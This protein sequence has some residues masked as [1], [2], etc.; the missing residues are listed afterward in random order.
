MPHQKPALFSPFSWY[1]CLLIV[2]IVTVL[3]L[4]GHGFA[5]LIIVTEDE[6]PGHVIFN[7]TLQRLGSNRHYKINN[8]KTAEFVHR[9]F[10][11]NTTS[12]QVSLK[13][14]LEC[15]GIFYPNLFTIYVDSVSNESRGVDYYSIP[16]RIFI[17]G[18]KCGDTEE[19]F[20]G[21]VFSKKIHVKISEAK[22]WISET[23]ASYAIPGA[24]G[25]KQIC[26]RKSQFI[27]SLSSFMPSTVLKMCNVCY[28]DSNN[29]RF[30]IETKAGD[31]VSAEDQCIV[32]PLWKVT[33]LLKFVCDSQLTVGG[34]NVIGG[35]VSVTEHRL[36]IIFHHQDLN[37][38]DIAHRV[39]RE[40]RNQSPYFEQALYIAS[41]MEEKPPGAMVATVKAQDPEK[42][43]VSYS[44]VSLLDSRSQT[45]F[46]V[47][48][49]SGIVT[50]LT[51]LDRELVDMHYFRVTAV[52]DSFPPRSGTTT[53]QI[54]VLDAN[55]HAP[56][57]EAS[58]YEAAVRES[59]SVGSTVINL[60]ATDQDIN[61][62]AEVS[63][64]K[65]F[66]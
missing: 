14:S 9:L 11:V 55:D 56:E 23:L 61:R 45:M 13:R 2:T 34:K 19:E 38:T 27:S 22:K 35:L 64:L 8:H 40:L 37:D 21:D 4:I 63:A 12:G 58:E 44:M 7:T 28:I 6:P 29:P 59:V 66:S 36:K 48:P 10:H 60:R 26:L 15:D 17:S 42:S 32:E 41:V 50:T 65:H 51:S 46:T 39:R 16:L 33:V 24:D 52:D 20:D 49:R 43:P 18:E 5:Y 62:N 47:D 3:N 57:F 53:L 31:L 25:W 1:I 54:N 30:V